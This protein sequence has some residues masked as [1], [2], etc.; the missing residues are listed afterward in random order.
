MIE[1]TVG[2]IP[3]RAIA[4]VLS[5]IALS[6]ALFYLVSTLVVYRDTAVPLLFEL[7]SAVPVGINSYL[8][9]SYLLGFATSY[10]FLYGGGLDRLH[11]YLRSDR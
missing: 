9:L 1:T 5:G 2:K 3:L 11:G 10:A 6:T 4:L 7:A 8:A